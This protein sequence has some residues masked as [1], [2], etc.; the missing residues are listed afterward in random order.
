M[1]I[2]RSTYYDEPAERLDEA[3]L[4]QS[5]LRSTPEAQR[6]TTNDADPNKRQRA[7]SVVG[8]RDGLR[9]LERDGSSFCLRAQKRVY[10]FLGSHTV[11]EVR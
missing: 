6:I 3:A 4:A 10:D 1:G 5:G 2:T 9:R 11:E 7:I 8:C